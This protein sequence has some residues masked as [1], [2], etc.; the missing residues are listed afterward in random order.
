MPIILILVLLLAGCTKP[1]KETRRMMR[2]NCTTPE[3]KLRVADYIVKCSEAANPKSDEEGE[4][5]V[6]Q[7]HR[8]MESTL[9]PQTEVCQEIIDTGGFLGGHTVYGEWGACK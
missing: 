6:A 7:C 3:D 5:L 1:S 2:T 4:D 9:C 8:T